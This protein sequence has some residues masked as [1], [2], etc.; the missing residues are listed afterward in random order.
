MEEE[1]RFY[2][3]LWTKSEQQIINPDPFDNENIL[4][5]TEESNKICDVPI[6]IEELAKALKQLPNINSPGTDDLTNEFYNLFWL[7]IK[8]TVFDSLMYAY[9]NSLQY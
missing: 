9:N 2:K 7:D 3:K 6:S 1:E 4:K 5:L 8:Q